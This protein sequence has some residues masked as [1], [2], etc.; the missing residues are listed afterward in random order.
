MRYVVKSQEFYLSLLL[1]KKTY[2]KIIKFNIVLIFPDFLEG[3]I[4]N[5]QY[6]ELG[7]CRFA[8]KQ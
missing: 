3:Q 5:N 6:L 4:E 7:Q 8:P 1:K 2:F